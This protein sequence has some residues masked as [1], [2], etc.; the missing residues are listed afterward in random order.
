M[1]LCRVLRLT[2]TDLPGDLRGEAMDFFKGCGVNIA[3]L[4]A[5]QFKA[6]IKR[7]IDP[8]SGDSIQP[9]NSR[10]PTTGDHVEAMADL[11]P[12]LAKL[13]QFPNSEEPQALYPGKN[14]R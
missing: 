1:P 6:K 9:K 13:G 7:M 4:C 8:K 2:L 3:L 5:G 11:L 14:Q 10:R 12:S